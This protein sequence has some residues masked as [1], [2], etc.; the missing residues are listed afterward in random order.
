MD[1]EKCRCLSPLPWAL[2][3]CL[4]PSL[5]LAAH[6]LPCEVVGSVSPRGTCPPFPCC[7]S[8]RVPWPQQSYTGA[9]HPLLQLTSAWQ[10]PRPL[11][12]FS[13]QTSSHPIC[14]QLLLAS[15]GEEPAAVLLCLPIFIISLSL[16]LSS[17]L[18]LFFNSLL[19]P[20]LTALSS[21]SLWTL[22]QQRW[23]LL[24]VISGGLSPEYKQKY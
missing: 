10:D 3:I 5:P 23:G 14:K 15:A 7:H 24:S 12:A 11:S 6:Q 21:R 13:S 18:V 9:P 22:L 19:L 8:C 16:L 1:V 4:P 2:V 20:V 17:L